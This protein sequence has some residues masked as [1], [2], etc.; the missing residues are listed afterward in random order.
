MRKLLIV[1]A[2]M[3]MLVTRRTSRQMHQALHELEALQARGAGKGAS[4]ARLDVQT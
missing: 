4:L 1:L 3:A 2:L